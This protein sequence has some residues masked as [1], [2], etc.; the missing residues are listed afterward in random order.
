MLSAQNINLN[1]GYSSNEQHTEIQTKQSGLSVGVT[2]SSALAGKSAYDKS[3]GDSQ[4]SDSAVGQVM[5]QL[6]AVDKGMMAAQTPIVITGGSQKTQQNSNSSSSQTVLTEATAKSNLNIIANGG[7]LNSESAKMLRTH[8]LGIDQDNY[9]TKIML[10]I[11]IIMIL[12]T[13]FF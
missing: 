12:I 7:S 8:H 11:N 13:N 5:S 4:Y 3:M 10:G 2:Y 1:A 6:N 9:I